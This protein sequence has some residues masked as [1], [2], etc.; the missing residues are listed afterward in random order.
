M[1]TRSSV[2]KICDKCKIITRK[3]K[4]RVISNQVDWEETD[5]KKPSFIKNKPEGV[6]KIHEEKTLQDALNY[7]KTN[8]DVFVFVAKE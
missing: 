7:S 6:I 3:G 2:K 4:K 1:K 5:E 8:P